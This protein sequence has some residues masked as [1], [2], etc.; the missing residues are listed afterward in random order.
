VQRPWFNETWSARLPH[1]H[2][3]TVGNPSRWN[4]IPRSI[5]NCTSRN[6]GPN[7]CYPLLTTVRSKRRGA[8]RGT[9]WTGSSDLAPPSPNFKLNGCYTEDEA[10]RSRWANVPGK[11]VTRAGCS[12]GAADPRRR[13]ATARNFW[14]P[15]R[16][17][18]PGTPQF[19]QCCT[20]EIVTVLLAGWARRKQRSCGDAPAMPT[21]EPKLW[22][23]I[24]VL[25]AHESSR[26]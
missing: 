24:P 12:Q 13:H 2:R 20:G 1:D 3:S 26:I 8:A 4:I 9:R 23:E 19:P 11:S 10:G 17:F 14:W 15:S 21:V 25:Q 7:A 18:H 6:R 16:R 22:W 5:Q